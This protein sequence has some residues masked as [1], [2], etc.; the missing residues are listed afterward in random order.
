MEN[1]VHSI[2]YFNLSIIHLTRVLTT[3]LIQEHGIAGLLA[4]A[5]AGRVPSGGLQPADEIGRLGVRPGDR[6][7]IQRAGDV[8]PQVVEN[9]TRDEERPPYVFPDHCPECGSLAAPMR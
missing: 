5:F 2:V 7:V 8:I 9:L 4:H 6:V 1:K 3:P